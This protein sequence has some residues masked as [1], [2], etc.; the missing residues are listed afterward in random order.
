MNI[1]FSPIGMTDPIKYSHDGAMLHI[2]RYYDIDKV[3]MYMSKQ[4]CDEEDSDHR[5]TYCL[6]RLGEKKGKKIACECIRKPELTDGVERFDYFTEEFAEILNDIHEQ[7]SD[8][9]TLYLNISSGTPAM[10]STLQYLIPLTPY[11]MIPVQ[12]FT[13][14]KSAN[15]KYEER[16]DFDKELE[17][18][19]NEDNDNGINRCVESDLSSYAAKMQKK[20]IVTLLEKYDYIGAW[21]LA[22]TIR[23]SLSDKAF[24]LLT[25][26]KDRYMLDSEKAAAGAKKHGIALFDMAKEYLLRLDLLVRKGEYADFIR[27]LSPLL[28]DLYQYV[29]RSQCNLNVKRYCTN[30][31][32]DYLKVKENERLFSVLDSERGDFTKLYY[33]NSNILVSIIKEFIDN[34]EL[35][36]LCSKLR[37]VEERIR[38]DTAHELK[39]VTVKEIVERTSSEDI[40]PN[41]MPPKNI[42]SSVIRAYN[43]CGAAIGKNYLDTYDNMNAVLINAIG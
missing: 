30:G 25:A 15:T 5:F 23:S 40:S 9:D 34:E 29:L 33:N 6:E 39:C 42:I 14:Q 17:W 11:K 16:A 7:M 27:G 37:T 41:G 43:I 2:C 38:N 13:P 35:V 28:A 20:M 24:E 19:A 32:W 21:E 26:A 18:E 10:K 1:L 36:S 31:K 8:D 12:V 22:K 3:Y 4:V